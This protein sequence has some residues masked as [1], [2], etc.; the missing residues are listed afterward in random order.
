MRPVITLLILMALAVPAAAQESDLLQRSQL[1][2][3]SQ[4]PEESPGPHQMPEPSDRPPESK[5]PRLLELP[6]LPADWEPTSRLN[7]AGLAA[8]GMQHT[9][10]AGLTL[11]DGRQAVVTFWSAAVVGVIGQTLAFRCVTVFDEDL[12]ETGE[13][14]EQAEYRDE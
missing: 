9:G 2:E 7:S 8:V 1:P 11:R 10:T 14:C 13:T 6:G 4:G 12:V 5:L 3:E